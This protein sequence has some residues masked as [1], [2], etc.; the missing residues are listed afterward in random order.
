MDL[1]QFGR[2][3]IRVSALCLG[4]MTFGRE[5]DEQASHALFD[6][7]ID[8]GGN[9]IDTADTY[10]KGVSEQYIGNALAARPGLREKLIIA[11]KFRRPVTEDTN[12]RG[13]S[14]RHIR[15]SIEASLRRLRTDWVDL[16][17][18]HGW[19]SQTP[20]EETLSTL[21]DLVREGK[22][23]YIGASNY[24]G[25][26][27]AKAEGLAALHGWERYCALQPQYSLLE[28]GAERELTPYCLDA[29]LAVIPWSP[30]A[31][32]LL[33]GKYR[34]GEPALAGA[35]GADSTPQAAIVH[36]HIDRQNVA[37]VLSAVRQ[38]ASEINHS[39]AQVALNWVLNRPGV[40]AAIIGARTV[41]QLDDNCAAAGWRLDIEHQRLLDDASSITPGYPYDAIAHFDGLG[42]GRAHSV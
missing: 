10:A 23:R 38:V 33:T 41:A 32:G 6:R 22:V 42:S 14:R 1:R 13:A 18:I 27:L 21:N 5:C 15:R 19:D 17:Q 20:L 25:W 37:S 4:A 34:P 36:M 40:T 12:D 9:F 35:R 31:G 29:G 7:F 39:M 11:T 3:G 28:R 30:L 16:Y 2:T 24:A 26:H 8:L